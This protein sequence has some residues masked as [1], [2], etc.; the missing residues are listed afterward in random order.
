M[1]DRLPEDA[2]TI[3]AEALAVL[4]ADEAERSFSHL[5]GTF[6]SKT[7]KGI[8]YLYFQYSDPGGARR[9]FAIRRS[10]HCSPITPRAAAN[11]SRCSPRSRVRPGSCV[12]QASRW[13]R[14]L[15][16]VCCGRW[17]MRGSFASALC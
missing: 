12:R 10:M 15:R 16:R 9:Q 13:C 1:I 17:L 8:E 7:V 3:Y 5:A 6:T 2:Q 14:R 11:A 4:L